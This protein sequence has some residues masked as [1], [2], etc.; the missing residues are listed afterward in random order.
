[1][2]GPAVKRAWK[3]LRRIGIV[4][5]IVVALALIAWVAVVPGLV[6]RIAVGQ[7]RGMG[8]RNVALEIRGLSLRH[9]Q[10][11]NVAAGEGERLR[12]GAVGVGF[13]LGGL[14]KGRL[15]TIELTGLEADVRVRDGK[16]DL[17]PLADM[18]SSGEGENPFRQILLRSSAVL[19]DLEGQRLRIPVEGTI[20]DAGGGKLS[21]DLRAEAEGCGAKVTGSVDTNTFDLDLGLTAQVREVAALM[22]ALPPRWGKLPVNTSGSATFEGT[23]SRSRGELRLS[24]K[25]ETAG[26]RVAG[27]LI[28]QRF[29]VERLTLT[30]S[31]RAT[32]G[33]LDSASCIFHASG[34]A[35]GDLR[36]DVPRR[37]NASLHG[38]VLSVPYVAAHG[39]G[40]SLELH[41]CVAT[42]ILKAISG[43]G[44]PIVVHLPFWRYSL[45]AQEAIASVPE[46][47]DWLKA[48]SRKPVTVAGEKTVLTLTPGA[49]GATARWAWQLEAPEVEAA[50]AAWGVRIGSPQVALEGVEA[51]LLMAAR[52]SP[53]KAT[54]SLRHGSGL[55]VSAAKLPW[56]D[57]RKTA[58]G[59]LLSVELGEKGME[60]KARF[61]GEKPDWSLEV[62]ELVVKQAEADL[63][64]PDGLGKVEG[65]R[66]E[67]AFCVGADPKQAWLVLPRPFVA[68]CRS[69]QANLGGEA[70][71]LGPL[72]LRCKPR[73][74][75]RGG[76]VELDRMEP[77][78]GQAD[79]NIQV[80]GPASA[81]LGQGDSF[82]I[83]GGDIWVAAHWSR[84]DGG[85]LYAS[86]FSHD[87]EA[88][89]ER[90]L[91]DHVF[92]AHWPEVDTMAYVLAPLSAQ[93]K[94]LGVILGGFLRTPRGGGPATLSI[95]GTD[96][97]VG[98]ADVK[99]KVILGGGAPEVEAK[100]SLDKAIVTHK[101]SGLAMGGLSAEVPVSWNAEWPES[102]KF[103]VES[104]EAGG[105]KLGNVSGTIG[106]ADMRAEFTA[107][108]EPLKG[109]KVSVEG[110][111]DA[112]RGTPRGTA[113]LSLPLFKL[114]DENALGNLVPQLKGLAASGTFGL[115]GF[116]RLADGQVR[117]TLTLTVLDG[118]FR[119]K[120]WEADAEGA[121]ATVRLNSLTPPLTPRKELQIALVKRA[122]MGKLEV[123]DGFLA[124]R[125]EPVREGEAPAEPRPPA[126]GGSAGASPSRWRA[127]VQ[128]A[129]WGWC[130]GHLY[131]EGARFDPEAAEHTLT[132]HAEDLKLADL[133]ALVAGER[134]T[135]VGSVS[136]AL[137]VT[138]GKWPDLRFGDGRLAA[139]TGQTG[140]VRIRDVEPLK[141]SVD[142][143]ARAVASG[144][145]GPARAEFERRFGQ[146]LA[147]TVREFEYDELRLDFLSGGGAERLLARA[148]VKGRGRQAPRLEI[149]G[150]TFN[151]NIEQE[152]LRRALAVPRGRKRD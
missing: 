133:L 5:A 24:G 82:T 129:E 105:V 115:E 118:A 116:A 94:A 74:L 100:V 95:A 107:A 99:G 78:W 12:V 144:V 131:V 16:L 41:M 38:D 106:V 57:V 33:R 72:D 67:F 81:S 146:A 109:A 63:V 89:V 98:E 139:P 103:A 127:F 44:G 11:A 52:A 71:R 65:L 46:L 111:L 15:S 21:L 23:C 88:R 102:G 2:R 27:D 114:D 142:A 61:G 73:E 122:K 120:Q 90:K 60:A 121:F 86:L 47:K 97:T 134:A 68:S 79:L 75:A 104:I 152:V 40:W 18:S 19:L 126:Q 92:K 14:L 50:W 87:C 119:S 80:S 130:G 132:A 66:G 45:G 150:L 13:S 39:N 141:P 59:P 32:D 85:F 9:V 49:R 17:G 128:R 6:R 123:K 53:E 34:V 36:F 10:M 37:V 112:S 7:L 136:G 28:G 62:P 93:R 1:M 64:L 84:A 3:W 138:F 117:P 22:T 149:G 35:L 42:G 30:A 77:V 96:A 145:P 148:F 20:A 70:L 108:C 31:A 58:Q 83:P 4:A 91:G 110:S 26:L 140:W 124:F 54:L 135:G 137:P 43:E 151:L 147:E 55:S 8:L 113:R 29:S 48:D 56:L 125:L 143:A 69:A 76:G 101:A 51:K 25:V